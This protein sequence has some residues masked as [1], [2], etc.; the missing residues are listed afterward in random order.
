MFCGVVQELHECLAPMVEIGD[1]FNMEK[2]I[3]ERVRKD[4]VAPTPLE[5]APSPMPRVEEPTSVPEPIPPPKSKLEGAT[6][7][8]KLALVLRRQ[9]SPPPGFL[10]WSQTTLKCHL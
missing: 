5:R 9:L 2:K 1:L 6:S 3:W 4:P 7:P 10:L 8:E